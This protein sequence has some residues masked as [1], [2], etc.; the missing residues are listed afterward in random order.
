MGG[1]QRP[2]LIILLPRQGWI[3]WGAPKAQFLEPSKELPTRNPHKVLMI[4]TPEGELLQYVLCVRK[5][6]WL[7]YREAALAS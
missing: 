4:S 6:S 3:G 2:G 7:I 1:K 5:Q